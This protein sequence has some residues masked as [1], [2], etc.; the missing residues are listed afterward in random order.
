[1]SPAGSPAWRTTVV[2][3][4]LFVGTVALYTRALDYGFTNYDDPSYVTAN[5]HVQGGLSWAGLRWA[6]A[7]RTDYWHPLTWLSH[8][9][10][11]QLYGGRA[12]GHRLT[13]IL[14][15]AANAV[16]VFLVLRRLTGAFW[17]SAL[18]AALFAWHP[19]RVESVVWIP[20]R[21]DVM[22]GAFF[23][24]TLWAYAGYVDRRRAGGAGVGARYGLTL[25]LFAAGLMCKPVLVTLPGVLLLLDFWPLGR[26]PVSGAAAPRETAAFLLVEKAPFVLLSALIAAVTLAMQ[27][28][29]GAFSLHLSAGARLANAAVSL[30]RYLGKFFWPF[31]LT[32]CYPHPGHW[33]AAA[34]AAAT[35][36]LLLIT[37]LALWQWRSR[38]WLLVGWGWFL[39]LLLPSLG[40]V[41]AG[42]QA[43]ADRYTYLPALGLQLAGLWTLRGFTRA[44][45]PRWLWA[46]EAGILLAA[47][48]LRTW[49]HER[50]WHDPDILFSHA[51]E[52]ARNNYPAHAF[53]ALVLLGEG[54]LA[55][56]E[57][58]AERAVALQPDFAPA[59]DALA[60]VRRAQ[61]RTDEAI[62]G[63]RR[64]LALAP[65]SPATLCDLGTLLLQQGR[66]DEAAADFQAA[67]KVQPEFAAA[68]VGLALVETAR[69]HIPAAVAYGRR[70][71]ALTP[72]HGESPAGL[73]ALHRTIGD[74]LGRRQRFGEAEAQYQAALRLQ[75]GDAELHARLGYILLFQGQTAG[76]VTE[77]EEALR[78]KPDFPGLRDR[79]EQLRRAT[80]AMPVPEG[81]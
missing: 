48:A 6:F 42:Y 70:A 58:H 36:L 3:L 79:I 33:P 30:A 68:D 14:W 61:G 25:A 59:Q 69:D 76:A 47:C 56:A 71:L 77:W 27:R 53:Y 40:L 1:M 74:A 24:L 43:M 22:S 26:W 55:E 60:T 9:L 66:I 2:C 5:P 35:A 78:L 4:V 51:I 34:V 29:A 57:Q 81:R 19:L 15:H 80:T 10:D 13:S 63:Y 75:P 62:A 17:A 8:M 72:G 52:V 54:R 20:E 49:D 65:R 12:P 18:C 31:S 46:V 37:G 39:V 23:L 16:L 44:P 73:A 41:Q 11:W 45:L 67:L 7:G 28:A 38:P 21:K 50:V 64:V 32:V